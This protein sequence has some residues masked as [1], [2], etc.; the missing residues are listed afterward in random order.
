VLGYR[1]TTKDLCISKLCPRYLGP[2][3]YKRKKNWR[4]L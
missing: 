1:D 3:L 2:S 4:L